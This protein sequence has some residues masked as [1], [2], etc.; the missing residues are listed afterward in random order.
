MK[1]D[2]RLKAAETRLD[3]LKKWMEGEPAG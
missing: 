1:F 3:T 2:G